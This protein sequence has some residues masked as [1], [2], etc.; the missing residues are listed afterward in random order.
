MTRKVYEEPRAAWVLHDDGE[1]Y[2][3][4]LTALVQWPEGEWRGEVE[5]VIAP[6]MKYLRSVERGK[7]RTI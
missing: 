6:G 1:W 2:R 4:F 3:G 7:V 5:Y